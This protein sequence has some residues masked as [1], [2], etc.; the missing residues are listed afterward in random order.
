[1]SAATQHEQLF[2][3]SFTFT[4]PTGATMVFSF[5]VRRDVADLIAGA[6]GERRRAGLPIDSIAVEGLHAESS[7]DALLRQLARIPTHQVFE[8]T[9]AG[10]AVR[11]VCSPIT[12]RPAAATGGS[13]G[14][15]E[16][17]RDET[18]DA[19]SL[20]HSVSPSLPPAVQGQAAEQRTEDRG[21]EP[22]PPHGCWTLFVYLGQLWEQLVGR[23]KSGSRG[24]E[25]TE[26]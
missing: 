23:R 11:F 3:V 14:G 16:G 24:S 4:G 17:Q 5:P 18:G 6:A 10:Q 7:P 15:T 26:G 21:Q 12:G 19:P 2:V 1:M 8:E 22:E 13:D 25:V 20:P 9:I